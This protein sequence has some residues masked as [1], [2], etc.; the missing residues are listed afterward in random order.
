VLRLSRL[1]LSLPT[2]MGSKPAYKILVQPIEADVNGADVGMVE[3][4]SPSPSKTFKLSLDKILSGS[5]N[6]P[7]CYWCNSLVLGHV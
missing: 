2:P 7:N 6:Q 3:G 4:G 5:E 1:D